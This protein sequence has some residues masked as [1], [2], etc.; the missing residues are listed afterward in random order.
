MSQLL[1]FV[2]DL[3]VP[4]RIGWALWFAWCAAQWLWYR[5]AHQR[6]PVL[7]RALPSAGRAS[8]AGRT[9]TGRTSAA[10]LVVAGATSAP[11]KTRDEE[12]DSLEA[13][14]AS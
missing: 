8:R 12:S 10:A 2:A 3:S 7:V 6:A 4:V 11:P 9:V 1:E 5:R 14:P 13:L